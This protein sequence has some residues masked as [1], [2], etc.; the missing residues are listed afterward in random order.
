MTIDHLPQWLVDAAERLPRDQQGTAL[1]F[2]A[3][4]YLA[5]RTAASAPEPTVKPTTDD[6]DGPATAGQSSERAHRP[7]GF[8]WRMGDGEQPIVT[9]ST[10]L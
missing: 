5:G 3:A 10:Q 9:A 1:G 6:R 8:A 2:A 4:G 7:T